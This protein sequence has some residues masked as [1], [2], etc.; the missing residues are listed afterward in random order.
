VKPGR[1]AVLTLLFAALPTCESCALKESETN[2]QA[3]P[4]ETTGV[5][6]SRILRLRG[7]LA[8]HEGQHPTGT[9]GVMFAIYNQQQGGA[10]LWQEVQNVEVDKRGRFLA[11]LGSTKREG[12]YRDLFKTQRMLWLG[13]QTLLPGEV[14]QP[15]IQI[16]STADG[17]RARV[18]FPNDNPDQQTTPTT[19]GQASKQQPTVEQAQEQPDEFG[20]SRHLGSAPDP[21]NR[22][23][24]MRLRA[25]RALRR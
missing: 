23:N 5:D 16:V 24:S 1:I 13:E 20:G 3:T 2:P 7:E 12:I 22:I 25:R 15:R 10:P 9:V 17:L 18:M 14:E 8:D 4:S 21:R 19:S 6:R 11:L